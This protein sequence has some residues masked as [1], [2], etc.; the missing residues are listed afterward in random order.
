MS[1][2]NKMDLELHWL[3]VKMALLNIEMKEDIYM[4]QLEKSK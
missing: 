1:V 3:D 2:V 4:I